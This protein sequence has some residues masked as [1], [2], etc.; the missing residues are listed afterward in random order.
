M[1]CRDVNMCRILVVC[2]ASYEA[3]DYP[4]ISIENSYLLK[5]AI[6]FIFGCSRNCSSA[7]VH[8]ASTERINK[9]KRFDGSSRK[10]KMRS[11]F[12]T[13]RCNPSIFPFAR[14]H[15]DCLTVFQLMSWIKKL[16]LFVLR[17]LT[18]S[19]N[20]P[21]TE[22]TAAC[23][24]QFIRSMPMPIAPLATMYTNININKLHNFAYI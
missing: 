14:S 11:V 7:T 5:V 3:V 23:I 12:A 18:A 13:P 4:I 8:A 2:I 22:Y 6:F 10:I 17:A 16:I 19:L 1:P 15:P 21:H 20:A 24:A 9:E